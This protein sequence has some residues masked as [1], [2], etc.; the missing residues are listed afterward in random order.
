MSSGNGYTDQGNI[1]TD[2]ELK[3]INEVV[4]YLRDRGELD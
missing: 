4:E 2:K 3:S 1:M